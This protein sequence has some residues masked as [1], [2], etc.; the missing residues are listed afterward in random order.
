MIKGRFALLKND[1]TVLYVLLILITLLGCALRFYKLGEWS[2]WGDEMFTVGGREDGFNYSLVRQ[3]ISLSLIQ[4]MVAWLGMTEWHARLVP[5][6]FG[7]VSIP[8]LYFLVKKMFNPAT[9]LAAALLLAVSPWHLYWS[10][11]ARFYVPLL[12]FYTLALFFFYFGFE[13]D[14]PWYL[15]IALIFLGIATKERL[16]ALFFGPVVVGYLLLVVLLPFEKPA[17]L[18]W[19]NLAIFFLPGMIAG[20]F[21]VSPYIQDLSGWMTGFGYVN[22]NPVWIMLGV[23]YYVGLGVISFA[24][25]GALFFLLQK[26][27]AVLLLS[28]SA[29]LPLLGIMSLSLF[30]YTANR[31]VFV[32]LSSWLVLAALAAVE[33]YRQSHKNIKVLAVGVLLLLFLTPLSENVLYFK[34]QNGNRDDWRGAFEFVKQHKLADELVV[35]RNTELGD[36][37]VQEKTVDLHTIDLNE[38][39]EYENRVWFVEDMVAQEIYP[40]LHH[41]LTNN[42]RLV[43]NY[44]VHV[45]ARNFKMRVYLYEPV[46]VDQDFA[47]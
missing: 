25:L 18:R 19:R 12:L 28:L 21:F 22:N 23:V 36:F 42:A 27:R 9:G 44:D 29:T 32:A 34:Y 35:V 45:Q 6:L 41:W 17:G 5:A 16:L 13:E 7:V 33:L 26:N 10:Q 30:H 46:T 15:V 40:D 37:Y 24:G 20:G 3:S 2:F 4:F 39:E 47:Q 14:K 31:Y 8:T 43:A 1:K 38:V 11:N